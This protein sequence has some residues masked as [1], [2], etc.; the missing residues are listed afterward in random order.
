MIEK[1]GDMIAK[2]MIKRVIAEGMEHEFYANLKGLR[3][4]AVEQDGY[5][6][7]ETLICADH[8]NKVMVISKWESLDYW[9]AWK[10]SKIRK[11]I[12]NGLNKYEEQPSEY[13]AYVFSKY[14]TAVAQG[15]PS[16]LQR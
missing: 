6:S 9:N 5:I 2:V 12:E 1:G 10:N 3:A 16:P 14:R 13:E 4:K 11:I 7:G 15:F 8:P